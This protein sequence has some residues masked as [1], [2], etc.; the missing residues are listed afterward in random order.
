MIRPRARLLWLVLALAACSH[1]SLPGSG[2]LAVSDA[3]GP[4]ADLAPPADA[5]TVDL[6]HPSDLTTPLDFGPVAIGCNHDYDCRLYSSYCADRPCQ[7]LAL[8]Q[9]QNPHCSSG[10]VT[11]FLDPCQG[12]HAVCTSLHVC[13]AQ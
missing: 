1:G 11:C 12:K 13:A 9:P 7:C 6:S 2:D 4:H 8:S 3:A 10:Y 5:A